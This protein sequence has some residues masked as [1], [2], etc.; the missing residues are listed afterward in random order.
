M[1]ETFDAPAVYLDLDGVLV[2]MDHG[3]RQLDFTPDPS[4]NAP[5]ARLAEDAAARK[6]A[7]QAAIRGTDFYRGLPLM[8]DALVLWRACRP[9]DP[10]ILTAAPRFGGPANNPDFAHAA[11]CKHDNVQRHLG[12]CAA[13]RVICT[14]STCKSDWLDSH[15]GTPQILIDDRPDNCA[16]WIRAGGVAIQHRS[17]AASV[18]ELEH[19]LGRALPRG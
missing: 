12:A 2:N 7:I 11:A 8:H 3:I 10:I 6:R 19:I 17:A 9:L 1:T 14:T 18:V 16:A 5:S 15:P 13:A 4:L